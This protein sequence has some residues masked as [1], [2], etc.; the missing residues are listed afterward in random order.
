M[1]YDGD[2]F[3]W[4]LQKICCAVSLLCNAVMRLAAFLEQFAFASAEQGSFMNAT[5]ITWTPP[6][7]VSGHDRVPRMHSSIK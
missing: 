1:Q 6:S 4:E 2:C 3:A 7:T 5:Y